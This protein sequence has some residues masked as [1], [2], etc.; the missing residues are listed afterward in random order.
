MN[1]TA[2]AVVCVAIAALLAVNA[3]LLLSFT[4]ER[5]EW[6]TERRQLI[7]RVIAQHAGEVIALD[8]SADRRPPREPAD[9][10]QAVGLG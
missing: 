1:A 4:K 5:M 3:F 8:R 6:A 9:R 2:L 10:P 7:D